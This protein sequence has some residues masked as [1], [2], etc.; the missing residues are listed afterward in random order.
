MDV[1]MQ[2]YVADLLA[3]ASMFGV[4][5]AGQMDADSYLRAIGVLPPLAP[6][7]YGGG[8]FYGDLP[9]TCDFYAPV[10]EPVPAPPKETRPQL[11][12]P[13]DDDIEATLRVMEENTKERPS[14]KFLE[15]TQGGR[16]TPEVRAWMVDFM[17]RFSRCYDLAAGTVHRAVYYLD[18]YLSVTPES[19][20]EMQ[21]RLVAA[22][23]ASTEANGGIVSVGGGAN[24]HYNPHDDLYLC[25]FLQQDSVHRKETPA[26]GASPSH[27]SSTYAVTSKLTNEGENH[28]IK[29]ASSTMQ[30]LRPDMQDALA[31]ELDLD[32]TT[33]FFGV[34]DGHGGAEVAMYCAKRFHTMLLED[35]DYLNNLP[36]AITSVCSRL[37]GDLQ[38]SNEWRESL[39]RN[40]DG[41]CIQFLPNLWCSEGPYVAPLQEG[42]TAC[43]VIIRGDQIIVG[44]VGDSRCVLLKNGE[45]IALSR[46]HKP[47]ILSERERI[48]RAGGKVSR[49]KIPVRGLFGKIIGQQWGPYRIQGSLALSRAIG[50]FAFKKN[51]SMSPSQQMVT[52]IPD[53]R[54]ETITDDTEFLVIASDGIWDRMSNN[55]VV[56]CAKK[57]GSEK[58]NQLRARR[59]DHGGFDHGPYQ[60]P[61][62]SFDPFPG[63]LPPF[64]PRT[65]D[66][67][68]EGGFH[69]DLQAAVPVPVPAEEITNSNNSATTRPHL[70]APYDDDIE[71]TLRIMEKNTNERP[72]TNFLEDTQGGQVTAEQHAS[73][74]KFMG[75]FSRRYKLAAGT[76]HRAAN[77]MDR[78]LS[79]VKHE[80]NDDERRL[81]LV[82]ATAVFLAA[83][84]EDQDT[85]NKLDTSEVAECC[86]YDRDDTECN[87]M[88]LATESKILTALDYNLSGPTVYTFVEH[89]TRYYDDESEEDQMVQTVAHRLADVSLRVYGFHRYLPSVV[90]A[91][92][93]FLARMQVLGEP[94]SKDVA[95]LTGYKAIELRGCVCEMYNIL[96]NP[97]FAMDEEYFLEDT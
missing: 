54:V 37:D 90:A 97:R 29:Y 8:C 83:K 77:Y 87:R 28:R 80:S 72:S 16:M 45:T 17:D 31:V 55:N 43:V 47:A 44:N 67:Y 94:W 7:F 96:P 60:T 89:F 36:S 75:R 85:L 24:E 20:D 63:A 88:V 25:L 66:A 2:P 27:P 86:G 56:S 51:G 23:V 65:P 59:P 4:T 3:E 64:T 42:S 32:A 9:A 50:D 41:K 69:G 13:Y 5:M 48:E 10:Q 49:D 52:C 38:R 18:R 76:V 68:G 70:C 57:Y 39:Y 79:V 40:S 81:R 58:P 78:Y 21:L 6:E 53:I 26:M 84:Y 95:E 11:C 14:T 34:Y 12:A 91:A 19:D 71:A 74:I 33:S 22:T 30:G 46:D 15:D 82:A 62:P 73:L 92:S 35:K 61:A 1:M 93:I